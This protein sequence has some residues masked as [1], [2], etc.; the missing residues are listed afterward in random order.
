MASE[1][2][3]EMLKRLV[4][5]SGLSFRQNSVSWIFTCPRCEKKD[6]L[7][8]R[9]RDGR[10]ICWRC[11]ETDNFQGRAEYLLTELLGRPL[12]ELRQQLYGLEIHL[13]GQYVAPLQLKDFY[14]EDD[15]EEEFV[16]E[17]GFAP[18][19][20]PLDFY[21]IDH[22]KAAPGLKYLIEERGVPVD[23]AVKYG[24]RYSVSQ[25]RVIFPIVI[26][27]TLVGWQ[28][29]TIDP[30]SGITEDGEPWQ[31]QKILTSPGVDRQRLLMFQDNLIGLDYA[32]MFE[33]PLDSIKADKCGGNVATMGAAVS[34]GQLLI[35]RKKGIKRLYLGLDPDA[36]EA[37]SHLAR[38]MGDLELFQMNPP[39]GRKD[40]GASTFEE[41]YDSFRSA[42]RISSGNVF[43][44]IRK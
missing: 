41:T 25:R 36:A 23:I 10:F 33:G 5:Q 43:I 38:Q 35:L 15:D 22:K 39:A 34:R 37:T 6:K 21:S 2:D 24:L 42:R 4:E 1:L 29:R 7:Y 8:L 30:D 27:K 19:A 44:F 3:A 32:T 31:V 12:A 28:A 11:A 20:F 26:D 17:A 16:T 9:K 40:F 18:N 14:G 13:E